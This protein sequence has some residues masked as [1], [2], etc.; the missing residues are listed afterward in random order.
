MMTEEK[1]QIITLKDTPF[2]NTETDELCFPYTAIKDVVFLWR[3]A[4][5]EKVGSIYLPDIARPKEDVAIGVILS[6]GQGYYDKKNR[7]FRTCALNTG[8]C[9]IFNPSIPWKMDIKGLDEVYYEVWYMGE[10]DVFAT[11]T[12]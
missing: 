1:S 10:Q 12:E 8:D 11:V 9:V 2:W 5:E 3:K 4:L 7:K 6:A